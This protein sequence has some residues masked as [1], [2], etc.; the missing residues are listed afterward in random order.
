[1]SIR[2]KILTSMMCVT[3]ACTVL[4]GFTAM[5]MFSGFVT[6]NNKQ[7]LRTAHY[8]TTYLFNQKKDNAERNG[9]LAALDPD[10]ISGILDYKNGKGREHMIKAA[11]FV[12]KTTGAEFMTLSDETGT[13]LIR[14]HEP[15]KH[16][17]KVTNQINVQKAM[18]GRQYTTIETG[19]VVKLSIRSGVPVFGPDGKQIAIVS[20][21]YR[22]DQNNFVDY[23]K[24][25]SYA[26]VTIFLGDTRIAT[27][28][29]NN[30]GER[31]IGTQVTENLSKQV[32]AGQ[33]FIGK[34]T[35]AGNKNFYAHYSPIRDA[36]NTIIGMLFSGIDTSSNNNR[37]MGIIV[38]MIIITIALGVIVA[39]IANIISNRIA[40]PIHELAKIGKRIALGNLDIKINMP[41]DTSSKDETVML[42]GEFMDLVKVSQEQ[43]DLIEKIANGDIS[44]DIT[45]KSDKDKLSQAI[46]HMLE[47]TKEQVEVME[48]LA[49]NDLTA[50]I[51]P[52]CEKDLMNI[53]I[54]KMLASLN[55]TMEEINESAGHFREV[56]HQIS[57]GSQ[58]LA[59]GSNSQ[60][61]S[62]EEVSSSL[63]ETSSMTKQNAGNSNQAKHL[64]NEVTTDLS[65]ADTA[66]KRMAQAIQQIKQSSDN[67]AKIIKTID[68]IAFQTNLLALNAAVEAARAGEAGKGFAVVAEEV[69]NLAMRS[70]EAAKNTAILIDESVKKSDDGVKITE[71]VAKALALS[72]VHAGKAGGLIAEI[73]AASNEQAQGI[74]QVNQAVTQ[75]NMV[76]QQNAANSEESA[77]AAEELSAQASE[78]ANMISKFKLANKQGRRLTHQTQIIQKRGVGKQKG[79]G[80]SRAPSSTVTTQAKSVK[81]DQIIPLDDDELRGF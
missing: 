40:N 55:L 80:Y 61:S 45:P 49:D 59:E 29:K 81:P 12:T 51:S 39:I 65:E 63:E 72:I 73:A 76:T 17:D 9:A 35:V 74:E 79:L 8:L 22:I 38:I 60:A 21:G 56:S 34:A 62:L 1:M 11:N 18:D 36:E 16:G 69:R 6:D 20:I 50:A 71:E 33:D 57:S 26:E 77:S 31:N 43:A 66:M 54:K 30:K 64:V 52:R 78:L 4:I 41:A 47:A 24:E 32:L 19:T 27:T 44:H 37:I 14:T 23:I 46:H 10:L 13:V 3:V 7:Q 48:R 58:S 42:A 28:I 67:T 25:M 68:E 70:A 5:L 75:V 2:L 15:E 53:A